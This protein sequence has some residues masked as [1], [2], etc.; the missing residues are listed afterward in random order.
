MEATATYA[1]LQP[2]YRSSPVAVFFRLR[3]WTFKHYLPTDDGGL[4]ARKIGD[5]FP[6]VESFREL[7]SCWEDAPPHLNAP[8]HASMFDATA[9]FEVMQ[10]ACNFYTQCFFDHFGRL[11]VVLHHFPS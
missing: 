6:H 2:T 3:N 5:I 4:W 10:P 11:P 8:L 1:W 7:L 9:Y